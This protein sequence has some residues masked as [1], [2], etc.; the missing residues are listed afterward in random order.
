M[1]TEIPPGATWVDRRL[2]R[3]EIGD[4]VQLPDSQAGWT[5][6]WSAL[7]FNAGKVSYWIGVRGRDKAHEG[8]PTDLLPCLTFEGESAR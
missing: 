7:D 2:D 1:S 3:I 8:K 4:I 6:I 5:V